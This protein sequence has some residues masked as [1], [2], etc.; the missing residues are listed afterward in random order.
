MKL[1]L[2]RQRYTAFGGAERFIDRALAALGEQ[3]DLSIDLIA[4]SWEGTPPKGSVISCDPFYVGRTWR[5]WSFGRRAKSLVSESCYDL[6]QSHER[7][8]CCDIFRAGDGVHAQW[9]VN[10]ARSISSFRSWLQGWAPWH[11][12]TLGAERKLFSSTK[13]K[14]VIC[15]SN[16]V[17]GEIKRYFGVDGRKIHVIYNGIDLEQFRPQPEAGKALRESLGMPHN[18][19]LFLHVGSGFERKGVP[20]LLEAFAMASARNAKPCRLAI[21]GSDRHLTAMQARA[22]QLGISEKVHFPGSQLDVLKW[23]AAA[24][25]FVLP[26]TYDPFPNAVM[27]A[28]ACGLPVITSLQ[29]GAAE[30][31]EEGKT[32]W[33][34][35]ALD[36]NAFAQIMSSI[37]REMCLRMGQQA[38]R[39]AEQFPISE[40]AA[41]M[42][43]LY[44]EVLAV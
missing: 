3:K 10:R 42:T 36:G 44:R 1:A 7:I 19:V 26:T 12:Y 30:L 34:R 37:D 15:N 5:D 23:Y 29:C 28:L 25:C 43:A 2:I 22:R 6:V 13:L 35:D 40:M 11:L 21:V 31:L 41:K 4:R 18:G 39:L 20:V 8:D 38:R 14:A 9:L 16:M 33:S 24:D 17:A 27:E 32:G